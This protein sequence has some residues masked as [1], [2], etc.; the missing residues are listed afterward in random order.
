MLPEGS[1][2]ITVE[3]DGFEKAE[4]HLAGEKHLPQLLRIDYGDKKTEITF[5]EARINQPID[6]EAFAIQ[7][8]L[9]VE[10]IR[11]DPEIPGSPD[12]ST[13][14]YRKIGV[15]REPGRESRKEY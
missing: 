15:I 11:H 6:S 12:I 7:V 3:A 8:P 4:I 5:S 2:T 1:Y 9:D 10:V 13:P 14:E